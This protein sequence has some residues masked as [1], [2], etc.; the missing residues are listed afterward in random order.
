[1]GI[2][3]EGFA[4]SGEELEE[5]LAR[6][7]GKPR[8]A[9]RRVC[10][11]GH[12]ASKHDFIDAL[13]ISSCTPSRLPCRCERLLSVVEVDDVRCFMWKTDGPGGDHALLRG[14]ASLVSKGKRFE[15]V[16]EN[17]RCERC[18][19]TDE[20]LLPCAVTP[21]MQVSRRSEKMNSLLCGNCIGE[22]G[23]V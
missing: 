3:L 11:C 20:E 12:S 6:A 22:V 13:G 4:V 15:W 5:A 14:L 10:V 17:R 8:N 1:M 2:E 9:D 7:R 18:G 23:V 16:E 19:S 21:E